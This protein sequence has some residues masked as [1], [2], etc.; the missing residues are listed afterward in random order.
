MRNRFLIVVVFVSRG[1]TLNSILVGRDVF[2][3]G[4]GRVYK[5]KIFAAI[6]G[7]DC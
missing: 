2:Q 3:V 4:V 5:L 7:C 6:L 1:D